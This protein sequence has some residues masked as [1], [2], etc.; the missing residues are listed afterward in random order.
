MTTIRQKQTIEQI[1]DELAAKKRS[2]GSFVLDD[3]VRPPCHCVVYQEVRCSEHSP[4]KEPR[5]KECHGCHG[6][7]WIASRDPWRWFEALWAL[8][9]AKGISYRKTL[10][11]I[12]AVLAGEA[13]FFQALEEALLKEKP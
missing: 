11:I 5:C 9:T 10:W 8:H 7:G 6:K 3:S 2:A 13:S 12:H 4:Y 1:Q